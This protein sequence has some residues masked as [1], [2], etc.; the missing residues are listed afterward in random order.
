MVFRILFSIILLLSVL[1]FPFYLSVILALLG[2]AYFPFFIEAIFL[3]LLSDL[4][5]GAREARFF[6]ITF[7]SFSLSVIFFLIIE[8]LKKKI[9]FYPTEIK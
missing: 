7:I 8:F 4:L 3:L 9:R 5:Y 6:D 1:F 2:M